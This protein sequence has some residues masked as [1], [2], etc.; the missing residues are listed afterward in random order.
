M[1]PRSLDASQLDAVREVANIGAAHAATALSRMTD[2]TVMINV[3]DVSVIR[4]EDVD[5]VVAEPGAVVAAIMMRLSGDLT[6]RMVQVF[7][8]A[9]AAT[10]AGILLGSPEP[11]FPDGY[12]ELH[13]SALTEVG[14]I[15]AGAHLNALAEFMDMK[16]SMSPPA[17]AIDMAGAVMATSYLNFGVEQDYAFCVHTVMTIGDAD[18]SAHTLLLPDETSLRLMLGRM[19]LA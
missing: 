10:L 2:R 13:R 5:R 15:I 18:V 14:N 19:E 4:L 7:P 16:L 1:D 8:P 12:E 9:S 3:P 17:L 11:A 6:G